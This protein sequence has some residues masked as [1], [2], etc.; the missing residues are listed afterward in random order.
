MCIIDMQVANK[1]ISREH[2]PTPTLVDPVHTLISFRSL[3]N[4]LGITRS[5]LHL[6]ANTSLLLSPTKVYEDTSD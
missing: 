2:H 6:K 3:I 5:R 1:A 4:V